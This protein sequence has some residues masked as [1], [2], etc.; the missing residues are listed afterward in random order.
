MD[1]KIDLFTLV[2]AFSRMLDRVIPELAGHHQ[3]VGYFADKLAVALRVDSQQ[4]LD[5]VLAGLLHD[6]GALPTRISADDLIFERDHEGHAE[7]GRQ[8]LSNCPPLQRVARI[9]R[10]HHT[11][12]PV[13]DKTDTAQ[14]LGG[15][16]NL[17]DRMDVFVRSLHNTERCLERLTRHFRVTNNKV[18]APEYVEAMLT[19]LD[20]PDV[21]AHMADPSL[22]FALADLPPQ[23]L[24]SGDVRH[25]CRFMGHV[26]DYRS[27]FTA[28]HSAGVAQTACELGRL[29]GMPDS[30]MHTLYM[31]GM[32]HDIGKLDIPLSILEKPGPLTLDEAAIMRSHAELSELWLNAIPGFET[33]C[34]WGALHHERLNGGGYP[35][36]YAG[37]ELCLASRIMA[38]ADVFTA[39]TEDRP[40]R[41][42]MTLTKAL[43]VLAAMSRVHLDPDLVILA[44]QHG[45]LLDDARRRAQAEAHDLYT[46]CQIPCVL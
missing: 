25:F 40:Y 43:E 3:R 34:R 39:V 37:E 11:H 18:F 32:L 23:W 44:H 8:L 33:I 21:K 20:D 45:P 6:V 9:V 42:G 1:V 2:M 26:I 5:L 15:I 41:R 24:A 4:R 12:W 38:V 31:A 17:A 30:S 14:L 35:H 10:F 46:L 36:G 27:P 22:S 13:I 7:A 29:A 28:T 16:I 19:V